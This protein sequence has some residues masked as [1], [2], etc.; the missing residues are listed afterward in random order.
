MKYRLLAIIGL[1]AISGACIAAD[2]NSDNEDVTVV[3]QCN[4]YADEQEVSAAERDVFVQ[5]CIEDTNGAAQAN[6]DA[7]Q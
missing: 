1:I 5:Q 2:E 6:Y 7:A 3:A 4:T